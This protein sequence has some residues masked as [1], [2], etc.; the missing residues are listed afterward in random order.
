MQAPLRSQEKAVTGAHMNKLDAVMRGNRGGV[1]SQGGVSTTHGFGDKKRNRLSILPT[2]K[3][4]CWV[5][6]CGGSM[7]RGKRR[8]V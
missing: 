2:N 8:R 3:G 6:D 7:M 4:T 5:R 1:C